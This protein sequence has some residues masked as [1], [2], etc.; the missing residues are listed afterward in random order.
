MAVHKP[1]L[2]HPRAVYEEARK[3]FLE[4]VVK[5]MDLY[6]RDGKALLWEALEQSDKEAKGKLEANAKCYYT[7]W[8]ALRILHG[9]LA[10]KIPAPSMYEQPVKKT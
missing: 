1:K 9:D 5:K 3:D 7:A 2:R 10:Y 4:E 6:Q 8:H